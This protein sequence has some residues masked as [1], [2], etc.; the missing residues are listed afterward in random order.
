MNDDT[1]GILGSGRGVLSLKAV[2]SGDV[3][4]RGLGVMALPFVWGKKCSG[5]VCNTDI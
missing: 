1:V 2:P 5:P 4:S 3:V